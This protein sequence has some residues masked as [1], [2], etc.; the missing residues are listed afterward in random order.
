MIL[1]KNSFVCELNWHR[2]TLF[3][4]LTDFRHIL[5]QNSAQLQRFSRLGR[6]K[7]FCTMITFF[8]IFPYLV[9]SSNW[10]ANKFRFLLVYVFCI[11]EPV[12]TLWMALV[13]N[14][15]YWHSSCTKYY[16]R[17]SISRH[18]PSRCF[19]GYWKWRIIENTIEMLCMDGFIWILTNKMKD[20]LIFINLL[21]VMS[22]NLESEL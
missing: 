16:S 10:L 8:C 12:N 22:V 6:L 4:Y 7:S 3:V 1:A 15:F 13:L 14:E 19:D 11:R 9:L 21:N 18:A 5:N 2:C 17:N 20:I